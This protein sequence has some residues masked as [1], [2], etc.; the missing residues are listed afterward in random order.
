MINLDEKFLEDDFINEAISY[1]TLNDFAD[2]IKVDIIGLLAYYLVF[3]GSPIVRGVWEKLTAESNWSDEFKYI[4]E[5]NEAQRVF[6]EA[7][8]E[9]WFVPFTENGVEFKAHSWYLPNKVVTKR[10][11]I[12]LHGFRG[13][14][15]LMGPWA[16]LL[17]LQEGYNVLIPTL[18]GT[19]QSGGTHLALGWN[20]RLD[21][22]TWVDSII[23]KVG[24][25]SEIVLFGI[26]AGA[27]TVMMSAGL[28]LPNNVKLII[29]DCGYT[30]AHN[31]IRHVLSLLPV[32]ILPEHL[33]LDVLNKIN[34]IMFDKQGV[35]LSDISAINCVSNNEIP[36]L[37]IQSSN[38]TV[39]PKEMA[40]QLFSAAKGDKEINLLD[41]IGHVEGILQ[42][43]PEYKD[44]IHNFIKK[45]I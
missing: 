31:Q 35:S 33:R 15:R 17:F 16:E 45:H 14:S 6:D 24:E 7:D 20:E 1:L 29:E 39:V 4:E 10:T 30:D 38:D 2:D 41:G 37:F 27:A 21:V 40:E 3:D 36:T 42:M 9:E 11:A 26:S 34:E 8:K 25:D 23:S 12:L 18:R 28:T 43:L 13:P 19:W 22:P 5:F 32:N 44:I